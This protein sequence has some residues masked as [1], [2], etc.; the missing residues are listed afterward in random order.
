M[1]NPDVGRIMPQ[2]QQYRKHNV[3]FIDNGH[4]GCADEI[5][6]NIRQLDL[7]PCTVRGTSLAQNAIRPRSGLQTCTTAS[8]W[9]TATRRRSCEVWSGSSTFR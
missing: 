5:A 3:L 2:L 9:T 6:D 7:V 1:G 8:S 4:T